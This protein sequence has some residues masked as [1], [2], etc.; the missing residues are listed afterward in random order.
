MQRPVAALC[1]ALAG[2]ALLALRSPAQQ[3]AGGQPGVR[4]TPLDRVAA[5]VGTKPIL[6][7]EVIEEINSKRAQGLPMPQDSAGATALALATVNELVDQ[8]V[9]V[10][11]ATQ[12]KADV[13][14]DEVAR[15]VEQRFNQI[16]QRFASEAEF[17]DALKR[18]GFSSPEEFRRRMRDQAK[19][20]RLQQLGVDSLRAHGRLSAPVQITEA[21]VTEAFNRSRETLPRRPASVSFRQIVI[22]PR[23]NQ[24]AR[25]S[26]RTKAESLRVEIEK[27]AD[28]AVVAKRESM[29]PGSRELGGDLGWHRRGG[30]LVLEFERWLFALPP[31]QL[32]PVFET[33]FGF[34]IV[35][36][37]RVQ[38][39]EVKGRHILIM[40]RIDSADAARARARADSVLELWKAGTS[41]DSLVARYH[42]PAELKSLLDGIPIDSL[43]DSYKAAIEGVA[44]QGWTRPFEI[45]DPRTGQPKIGI[46]QITDR[47][48]GGEYTVSDLK[49]RIR[50]QLVQ[51]KQM[52]RAIDQLRR[53]QYVKILFNEQFLR[54]TM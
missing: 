28:F 29:D 30:D 52:R 26:A 8:E 33:T 27:G 9:L 16:R 25:D 1:W 32:S 34:H 19:R 35:R 14:D 39:A 50:Q 4:V 31:G 44:P 15:D 46:L 6:W 43:P 53:E 21:E 17:R 37:D 24:A 40:P 2:A 22:A 51:E 49:D 20:Y 7:S 12:Y 23:P 3:P 38:P 47:S 5:V 45:P 48:E 42:D 18:E 41:Y 54:P 11:V 36:V 13:T 10:N